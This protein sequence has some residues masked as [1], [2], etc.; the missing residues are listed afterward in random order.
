MSQRCRALPW[1][2]EFF[3][4]RIA[5]LDGTS[6]RPDEI[7]GIERWCQAGRI[8]CLYFLAESNCPETIATAEQNGFGF[9]DLRITYEWKS[10]LGARGIDPRIGERVK[11]RGHC[12][13]DLDRLV[14]IARAVHTDSRFFFDR[15]FDRA[16]AAML[17][18]I[19][20]RKACASDHVLIG[21][22]GGQPA[23]YLSCHRSGDRSGEIGLAAVDARCHGQ[24]IG[25][26][27]MEAAL[28][29]FA[30]QG[31]TDISVVTQGRNVAAHRFYQSA[32]FLT[33][34]IECWFHKWF[35]YETC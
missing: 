28:R 32:G 25:R 23:G 17:Y 3:S 19:W 8:E 24:G 14:E 34:A 13:A 22:T 10:A 30:E 5:R 29:W 7:E 18:E 16:H 27:M 4:R 31:V 21:E 1:D 15:R 12:E 9:K 6:L 2:S 11:V 35:D 33:R 26:A 20:I